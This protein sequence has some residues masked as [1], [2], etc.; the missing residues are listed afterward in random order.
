MASV[1]WSR[2][3][4]DDCL[5]IG[6]VAPDAHL[7][8]RAGTT[9]VVG[10]LPP[11]A[12]RLVRDGDDTCF[13]PRFAFLDGTTYRVAVDGIDAA[14]IVRPHPNG[15]ATT[16]VLDIRPTATFVPR[17]LLRLY[18]RFSSAMS[19]G[20][21]AH[22]VRLLDDDGTTLAGALL[23]TEHELWDAGH[24]R[25]TVLLD[26]ARIKRGLA[27]HREVGYPLRAGASFRLVIDEGFRDA[28][29]L[30]LRARAE[31]RY[32]V[33]DDERRRVD[34]DDWT[35]TVP[36]SHTLEPLVVAFD[37]PLD[38]GLLTRCLHVRDAHGRRVDGTATVGAEERSWSFAPTATWA[39]AP[40]QLAVDPV[41]EDL[42]GNSISR[43]FDRDLVRPEDEPLEA[44]TATVSFVPR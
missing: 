8:V 24:S 6:G 27:P 19:E 16:E 42:A 32:E 20:Y 12:G 35:L 36:P 11:M 40:H 44:R 13:I 33:G 3:G 9:V 22:H 31:R 30:P 38:H 14:V 43:V 1:S 39:A 15:P 26:P 25:L 34:P 23:P 5:R 41:L 18:V 37:L 17:N 10:E 4:E 7:R 29:G 21:A 28:R 2:Y